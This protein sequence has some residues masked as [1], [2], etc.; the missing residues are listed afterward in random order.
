[1]PGFFALIETY[2][3]EELSMLSFRRKGISL[4]EIMIVI[5]IIVILSTVTT[6]SI[7]GI[8][9]KAEAK[10]IMNNLQ[11]FRTA[12]LVW[13]KENSEKIGK[14]GFVTINNNRQIVQNFTGEQLGIRKYIQANE[15][16]HANNPPKA[17]EYGI[18]SV[19][20]NGNDKDRTPWYVGYCFQNGE[21]DVKK[22]LKELAQKLI[23]NGDCLFSDQYPNQSEK[24]EIG[25]Y[26]WMKVF[27]DR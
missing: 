14:D 23:D 26:F 5:A 3:R 12:V 7:S 13:S 2:R 27:Y 22:E 17:G 18:N 24:K 19:K 8:S 25:A 9:A 15:I 4:I 20:K 10:R 6:L 11:L 1:M 16:I 21:E